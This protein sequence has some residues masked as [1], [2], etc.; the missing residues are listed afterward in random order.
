MMK[1]KAVWQLATRHGHEFI[2]FLKSFKA[3]RRGFK[4]GHFRYALMVSEKPS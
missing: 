4:S 3:M 2:A 1:D